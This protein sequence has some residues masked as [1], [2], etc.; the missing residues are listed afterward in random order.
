MTADSAEGTLTTRPLTFSGKHLF[1]NAA[2]RDGGALR[3][4]LLDRDGQVIAPFTRDQSVPF[5]G[6]RTCVRLEWKHGQ[7][8][9]ALAGRPVRLRFT[10]TAG[11]LYAFW[12]S[13]TERGESGGYVAGGGPAYS[14]S[15]DR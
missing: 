12:V 13:G 9:A 5:T 14:S 11:S 1:V 3:A 4:E 15:R 10:L 8:L 2:V 7:D 6:D